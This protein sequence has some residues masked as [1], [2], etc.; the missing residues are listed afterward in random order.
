MLLG[1]PDRVKLHCLIRDP[2]LWQISVTMTNNKHET[3]NI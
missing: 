2:R 1:A 3:N